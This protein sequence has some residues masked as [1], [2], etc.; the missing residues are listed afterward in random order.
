MFRSTNYSAVLISKAVAIHPLPRHYNPSSLLLQFLYCK[1]ACWLSPPL[2]GFFHSCMLKRDWESGN[3][4]NLR[5]CWYKSI[6][7]AL[8]Y[9]SNTMDA[10][11][12]L[13]TWLCQ[14]TLSLPFAVILQG[15][16]SL[17]E[18]KFTSIS[19][20][21]LL[22]ASSY[23]EINKLISHSNFLHPPP[24]TSHTLWYCSARTEHEDSLHP[25]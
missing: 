22:P 16:T 7:S 13:S 12:T 5:Y 18:R 3:R 11:A 23:S 6:Y 24:K 14:L 8:P 21:F 17:S 15:T 10:P 4:C 9:S 25:P 2:Q 19:K 1:G 20:H